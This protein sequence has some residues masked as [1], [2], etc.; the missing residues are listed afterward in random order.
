MVATSGQVRP[1]STETNP[2]TRSQP[3]IG[4]PISGVRT[5]VVDERLDQVPVGTVGEL[6]IGGAGVARGYLRQPELTA[7]RFIPDPFG[8]AP[9]ARLYR[10]GDQVRL[11]SNGELEV[12]RPP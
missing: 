2:Q 11:D 6:L 1:I 8:G 10:T 12:L 9:D 5:Y 4:R 3:T 7:Q